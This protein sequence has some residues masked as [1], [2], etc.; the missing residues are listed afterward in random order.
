MPLRD[1]LRPLCFLFLS[2]PLV[3]SSPNLISRSAAVNITS[4]KTGDTV[5]AGSDFN[6]QWQNST[7]NNVT[8]SLRQGT[9]DN[10]TLVHVISGKTTIFFITSRIETKV[11]QQVPITMEAMP[12]AVTTTII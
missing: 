3:A 1:L 2:F 5:V 9:A 4:P 11:F 10:M 8:L 7:D 6:I 12:G